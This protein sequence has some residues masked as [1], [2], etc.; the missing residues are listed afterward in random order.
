M[1]G[2]LRILLFLSLWTVTV[3]SVVN[4]ADRWQS[5]FD[6]TVTRTA[7]VDSVLTLDEVLNL[8]AAHNPSLRSLGF[9][10]EA[11]QGRLRQASLWQN[12][13]F[14]T[15]FEEVGWDAP[16]FSETEISISLSQ[17]FEF[18]GQRTARK[19]VAITDIK[20]TNFEVKLAAFD[21]YLEA[22]SRFNKLL[23]SQKRAELADSSVFIAEH[24]V[25]TIEHRMKQGIALQ[26]ELLLAQLELQ[27]AGLTS[28]EAKQVLF[29]AQVALA[30]LWNS[31]SAT[32]TV[33]A[34]EEP[35]YREVINI[36]PTLAKQI[37]STRYVRR[38]HHKKEMTRAAKRLASVETKP[39]ITLSGGYKRLEANNSNSFLFG[40]SLPLPLFNRNQGKTAALEAMIRSNEFEQERA[41]SETRAYINSTISQLNQLISR[42]LA[43][44]SLLLPTAVNAYKTI[45]EN[46]DVGRIPFTSLLEAERSLIELRFQHNDVLNAIN[47]QLIAIERI[48]GIRIY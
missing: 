18:F 34:P 20:L 26:S 9:R 22:K 30:A 2:K 3:F 35:D 39:G 10:R 28:E 13:E 25:N 45:Q 21:L 4:A 36:L 27:R 17:Q 46:Y 33:S 31:N 5:G 38:L 44:D 15:E 8:V 32:I 7:A 40:I 12:P 42:H 19:Q 23:H 1:K 6:T 11:A 43:L 24:I 37:D 16:G 48:S 47:E 29:S 41:R 14:S